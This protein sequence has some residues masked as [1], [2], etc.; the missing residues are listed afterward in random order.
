METFEYKLQKF[1]PGVVLLDA[2]NNVQALN[3]VGIRVLGGIRGDPIGKSVFQLHPGKSREKIEWL[4][5]SAE[6]AAAC[7]MDSP[8]PMT[9]MI[10]IPDKVLLIKVSK[11]LSESKVV[12]TCLLFYDLT[13]IT[14]KPRQ[15]G[16]REGKPRLLFKLPV[17]SKNRVLLLDLD[18]VVHMESD[19][20]YTKVYTSNTSHFC[21]LSLSDMETRLNREQYV[22]VHRC[23]L[24]NIRHADTLEK[25]D[26]QYIMVMRGDNAAR[27]PISRSK[28]QELKE[29]LGLV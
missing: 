11:L 24:I 1:D 19:G 25:I 18:D 4:L 9:M 3:N 28:V 2:E 15:E 26:D 16:D 14:T 6:K 29:I 23:H 27:V 12:G 20:H 5:Q 8:P 10:N 22:R 13:D 17:Y 7:P 21:N